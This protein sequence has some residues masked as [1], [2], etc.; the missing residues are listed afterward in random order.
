M[1]KNKPKRWWADILFVTDAI[2]KII[3]IIIIIIK[4]QDH[5]F[6]WDIVYTQYYQ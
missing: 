6:A 4:L 5:A 1:I 3:I 2:Q